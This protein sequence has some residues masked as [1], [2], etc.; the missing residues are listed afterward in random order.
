MAGQMKINKQEKDMKK[1]I[2]ALSFLLAFSF[3]AF[4]DSGTLSA[5]YQLQPTEAVSLD[6][7]FNLGTS[8][9]AV[10]GQH[11][12]KDADGRIIFL[13]ESG[14]GGWIRWSLRNYQIDS[15]PD[16]S[17]SDCTEAGVPNACCTGVGEGTCDDL[18]AM[19]N[20]A[21]VDAG[22]PLPCCTSLNTGVCRGWSDTALFDCGESACDNY[23]IGVGL[24]TLIINQWKKVYCPGCN[25]TF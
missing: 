8:L 14:R 7:D 6:W 13:P 9:N 18:V 21:C 16:V 12:W 25:I 2:L 10:T 11:R 20:S 24:R 17:N 5:P 22:D 23:I 19:Q 15:V 3:Q 1:I 4:A